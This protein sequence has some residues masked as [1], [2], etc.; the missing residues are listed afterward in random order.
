MKKLFILLSLCISFSL[1]GSQLMA[2]DKGEPAMKT[3]TYYTYGGAAAGAVVGA[4]YF[5]IDPLGPSADFR[6]SAL[7]GAGVGALAGLI[8]G[9]MQLNR[10]AVMPG[11]RIENENEF[12]EGKNDMHDPIAAPAELYAYRS[13][14]NFNDNKDDKLLLNDGQK[15]MPIFNFRVNF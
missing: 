5:L 10:Q 6:R 14:P 3:V 8:L 15:E 9:I 12:L 1:I 2:Q 11:F 4:M 7:S 13:K